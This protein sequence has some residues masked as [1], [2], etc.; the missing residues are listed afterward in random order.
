MKDAENLDGGEVPITMA[1]MDPD[2]PS[3][4]IV[5]GVVGRDEIRYSVAIEIACGQRGIVGSHTGPRYHMERSIAISE[6]QINRL[7]T[8]IGHGEIEIA[9]PVEITGR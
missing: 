1:Q 5:H 8:R 7:G 6:E 9:I 4:A 2:I 3:R